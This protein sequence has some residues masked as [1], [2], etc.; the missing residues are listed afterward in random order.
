MQVKLENKKKYDLTLVI[1]GREIIIDSGRLIRTMDTCADAFSCSM[2]WNP[3]KDTKLDDITA[4]YSFTN[5]AVY[6]GGDLQMTGVLY[7]VTQK[8]G[9]DGILKDLEIFTQ[10]ADIIDSTMW[11]PYEANNISLIDRCKQQCNPFGIK[12][13]VGDGVNL[14]VKRKVLASVK[15]EFLGTYKPRYLFRTLEENINYQA[16]QKEVDIYKYKII[17]EE[18]KFPRVSAE[19]TETI[20]SH[21]RKLAAQRGCLLSCTKYGDLLITKA[22]LSDKPV[23]TIEDGGMLAN[24]YEAKFSGR[25]RFNIYR[26]LT[27]SSHHSSPNAAS[28]VK[29]PDVKKPRIF[30]FKSNENIPGG[31]TNAAKWAKN[32]HIAESMTFP[33][34]VNDWYAP[35]GKLWEP[36]T[37]ATVKSRILEATEGYNFLIRQT[38]FV[39]AKEGLNS[40]IS[41][42]PPF[43][44]TLEGE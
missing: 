19:A 31:G 13:I 38:E 21:L 41:L 44:Y 32:K 23:G 6:I 5:C 25:K 20:F 24:S 3:G 1:E 29:D 34:P 16:L 2:P 10:T 30:T 36:N 43:A 8:K 14:K 28:I 12:V 33:L 17:T 39:F 27:S 15:R 26:A 4:P 9:Q 7:D 11:P 37:T 35:N 22:N 42:I 18:Q 40:T